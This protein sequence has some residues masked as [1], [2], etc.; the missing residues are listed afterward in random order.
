M[1][2]DEKKLYH[3]SRQLT[4]KIIGASQSGISLQIEFDSPRLLSIEFDE[5]IN[6]KLNFQ[7]FDPVFPTIIVV[8]ISK[9]KY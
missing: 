3:S 2:E 4:W 5:Q 1:T 7:A 6:I 9:Q 8:P